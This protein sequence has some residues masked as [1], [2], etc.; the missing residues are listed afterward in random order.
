MVLLMLIT[1][2]LVGASA[3]FGL[4]AV[5][6]RRLQVESMLARIPGYGYDQERDASDLRAWLRAAGR[7]AP[8]GRG[9][10]AD[11]LRAKVT[12]AGWSRHVT[13]E[14]IAGLKV[15]LPVAALLLCM[16]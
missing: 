6:F 2:V 12:A 5:T 16:L 10:G 1:L 9:A 11:A 4:C 8:G 14:D 3:F 7:F 15:V 13:A